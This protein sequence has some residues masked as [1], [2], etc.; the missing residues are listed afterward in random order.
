MKMNEEHDLS[1]GLA[2]GANDTTAASPRE[3][4]NV[5]GVQF[6]RADNGDVVCVAHGTAIDVHCCNCHSG[7]L[8]NHDSCVCVFDGDDEPAEQAE[9]A[10]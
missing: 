1:A 7:F 6:V 9:E 3:V 5:G 4:R 2:A 8:F 10:A